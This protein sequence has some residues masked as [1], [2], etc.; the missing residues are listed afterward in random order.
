MNKQKVT[1]VIFTVIK[2]NILGLQTKA[3]DEG[4]MFLRFSVEVKLRPLSPPYVKYE[5][6]HTGHI[7]SSTGQKSPFTLAGWHTV[8]SEW[9]NRP[10][11]EEIATLTEC[12]LARSSDCSFLSV[13]L[14]Q[15]SLVWSGLRSQ[16]SAGRSGGT[17]QWPTLTSVYSTHY[18]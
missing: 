17:N 5:A 3:A 11:A 7:S 4:R 16:P 18:F 1:N 9:K 6:V 14:K 15:R 8:V 2:Y 12:L 10:L 13:G